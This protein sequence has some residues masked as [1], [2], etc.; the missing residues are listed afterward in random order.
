MRYIFLLTLL[1]CHSSNATSWFDP[2][3][4]GEYLW[5][6][7]GCYQ[8]GSPLTEK[9]RYPNLEQQH[10]VCITDGFWI[11]KTE[12]TQ[13][14]WQQIMGENPATFTYCGPQ[15][16]VESVSWK[17]VQQFID[18]LNSHYQPHH[19]A[20]PTNDEWEYVARAGTASAYSFG[21][22]A[23]N[24]DSYAWHNANSA[25][26][27]HASATKQANPWG[28]FDIHG[29]VWEWVCAATK[30]DP[31]CRADPYAAQMLRGGGWANAAKNLRSAFSIRRWPTHR[32]SDQGLRLK[33]LRSSDVE[34]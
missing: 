21:N 5:I 32:Y 28:L 15:C 13:K 16:P 9:G 7:P 3:S 2:V 11:G 27:T 34:R 1:I 26:R 19:Y 17:Q 22:D 20:L 10:N 25:K 30:A 18:T 31:D 24:I 14:Q 29:N 4:Q 23:T 8:Q 33:L 6:E 12:V